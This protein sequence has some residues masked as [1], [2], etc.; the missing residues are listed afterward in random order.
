MKLRG[1]RI[2]LGEIEARLAV[3]PSVARA[4]VVVREDIPGDRRLVGYVVPAGEALDLVDVRA[5]LAAALPDYMVPSALVPLD[6]L[7]VTVNGKLDR[8][9]LPAPDFGPTAAYRAPSTPAEEVLCEVFAQVLGVERVGLDD[10]FFE[11][12]GHSLL[13]VSLVEKLRERGVRVNVRALFTAPTVAGLAAAAG[14]R[15]DVPV[16]PNMVPADATRITPEM[17]PLVSLTQAEIDRIVAAVP[18]G[19]ANVADVYPLAPLQ[20]GLLFHHLLADGGED[21]YVLPTVLA[22]DSRD[23]LDAFTA[24]LQAV[25]DRHDVLRTSIVWEGRLR[26]PVQVVWRHAALSVEEMTLDPEATDPVRALLSEAGLSM[27]LGRAPLI[28]LHAASVPD[29]RWLLLIRVH[30]VIQDH[31]ALEVTRDEVAAILAGRGAQLP[32]PPPFRTFVAQA[33]AELDT[34]EHERFFGELLGDVDEPTAP[35]GLVDVRGDGMDTV[36][37][38]LEFSSELNERLR[39]VARR[40]GASPATVMHVAWARVL[41]AVSGRDDVVFGTVLFGRMNAGTG[42]DRVAG[43]FMNMLPVRVRVPEL[44]VRAAV[45]AMREQLAA[46]LE[47]EHAPLALAQQASGV[48]GD[49]P[50]FTA[51]LNYRHNTGRSVGGGADGGM[52]GTRL[53]F[54]RERTNY[55]LAVAVDDD[56]DGLSVVVDAVEP[57]NPDA[58]GA[59]LRTATENLVA[60]LET[61]L[62]VGA[63]LPL[64]AVEVLG[65]AE[66]RLLLAEW[67]DTELEVGR[68]PLPELFEA[69]AARTPDAVAVVCGGVEVTYAEL[70]ARANQVA[71]LLVGRGVRAESVVAVCME[72][73][74]GMVV[75]VLGVLKAG[76]AYLPIDPEYP[77]ERIAYVLADAH[78]R[79]VLTGAGLTDRLGLGGEAVGVPVVALDDPA[80][81]AEAAG[82]DD[83]ALTEQERG[84]P[85][86]PAHPAYVIYTSGSTGR[87]KGVV[88]EHRSLVNFL[89]SMRRRFALGADDRVLAVTTIGFDIAGL[90]LYLPL[91]GGARVVLATPDE[92]RDP[93]ALRALIRSSGVTTVQATPSLWQALVSESEESGAGGG[94]VLVGVRA[95]VGGEALPGELARTLLARTASVTNLYGPTETTIWSTAKRLETGSGRVS[96]IGGPIG[97]TQVYVLDGALAPVPAG[98]GGEL[99]IAGAGLARGYLGRP[100]LSAE[101]FVACPFGGPGQ[102]MYRTGDVVRWSPNG[103]LEFVGR[104]DDQVKVRG[105]RIEL[106]EI[107]AVVAAHP[108]VERAVVLV[109]EDT[110]GDKRLV[111]YVVSTGDADAL[112]SAVRE[113]TAES[114]PQYMVPAAVVVLEALPLTPNGKVDRKALPVPEYTTSRSGHG[115]S[116]LQE[117]IL[118]GLFAE[119]LGLSAVGVDDDF[120][121]LGGHSLL[122]TRLISRARAA[123]GVEVPL[124]VLFEAPSVAALTS[125]LEEAEHRRP[126]LVAG[127]RP[128]VLPVSFAQQRLW[129]LGELEG[130]SATYNIPMAVRLSG[131]VDAVALE[132]ALGDVVGRHEVLRT[133]FPVTD[134]QPR[135]RVLAADEVGCRLA[136]ADYSEEAVAASAAHSFDLS[137]EVPLRAW[138]FC[139]AADEHVLVVVVHHIA[140]DGWS[141]G[142][143]ARDLSVAYAARVG[144]AVPVWGAL[145]VQ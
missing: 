20:E 107:E 121:D 28:G 83:G 37:A 98:V 54:N 25:V 126:A 63:E 38:R 64:S 51:M 129:F 90:E 71:R 70:D 84:G 96:S 81:V 124:R 93:G 9:A 29:G 21:A 110:P 113:L 39:E 7:P 57:V 47:H 56:G 22:F 15:D 62:D 55:P 68:A 26:E 109:R 103:D 75:A 111:A 79:C 41:A 123:L 87:P 72:R 139:R 34:G 138:L 92:V 8:R 118:C 60:A 16:P 59:M 131:S 128:E 44:P 89:A 104:A 10:D 116:T 24:A 36:E 69:Q 76:A 18:G 106:G 13:A 32:E 30:H 86:Q 4:A 125:R 31:T 127:V 140:G 119:V 133:V 61:V 117:E 143:L 82:L 95:L 50:L 80:R 33:R 67:N 49:L 108:S 19:A 1:F 120:F 100:G 27:D 112:P 102:R 114:L 105:F 134:G 12:G 53:V 91:L 137:R 46:L 78:V 23:R 101:R 43:P 145:P 48:S 35:Y 42:S 136:V 122:A 144:G 141:L 5:R 17:L 58:V 65:E 74:I 88:V 142:P 14:T 97:N 94:N 45:D 132:A 52:A 66:Q 73:G 2:E 77:A 130:R 6:V 3:H 115:P 135:Q 11:L 40:L 99:Y 85:V